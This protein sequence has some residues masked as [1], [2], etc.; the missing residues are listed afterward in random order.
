MKFY[1]IK[2]GRVNDKIVDTWSE[3]Q[4]LVNGYSGARFKSFKTRSEAEAFLLANVQRPAKKKSAARR[5]PQSTWNQK[6]YPCVERVTYRDTATNILYK[7]K[8]IRRSGPTT[9][10]EHFKPHIGNSCPF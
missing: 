1:A 4:E 10:G 3:C 6:L 9:R 8:C 2:I 7:N 5:N